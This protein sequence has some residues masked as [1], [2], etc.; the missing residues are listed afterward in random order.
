MR[1]MRVIQ[2]LVLIIALMVFRGMVSINGTVHA[3]GPTSTATGN[4]GNG[5]S[6]LF[7]VD[8]TTLYL[9]DSTTQ[10]KTPY[11]DLLSQTGTELR[12]V[13]IDPAQHFVY[14]VEGPLTQNGLG[15]ETEANQ[16]FQINILTK[17]RKLLFSASDIT[18]LTI[19][20][21]SQLMLT[22]H[23]VSGGRETNTQTLCVLD[24]STGQCTEI[25][26]RIGPGTER[27]IDNQ[28]FVATFQS[29][30]TLHT[31]NA[32]TF[33]QQALPGL[34]S[35]WIYDDVLVPGQ[36]LL[37][38]G[39]H[40][41]T[42]PVTSPAQF[43]TLNLDTSQVTVLAYSAANASY[44]S[45]TDMQLSP[46]G[47]YFLYGDSYNYELVDFHTGTIISE[48][49]K[50]VYVVWT[51]DSQNL[52][53]IQALDDGSYPTI[54]VNAAT[55]QVSQ[56]SASEVGEIIPQQAL[57]TVTP[58]PQPTNTP[59]STPTAT[60]TPSVDDLRTQVNI[61]VTDD[62]LKNSLTV[63]INAGQLSAFINEV[64]AQSGKKIDQ[65]CAK[66]LINLA[67]YLQ[68]NPTPT[69]TKP[70]KTG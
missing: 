34:E 44:V 46:N 51:P 13:K 12:D 67:T 38:I 69:A 19:S 5:S 30:Q 57:M 14:T 65:G 42:A 27:W 3:Q 6:L 41:R 17:D 35:W 64:Q 24:T 21:D 58:T 66:V 70:G 68:K 55:G 16:V 20:P 49:T 4:S 36:R 25:N 54:Q 59:T 26:A 60:S 23:Y 47:N 1:K 63:K 52:I 29:D 22:N 9:W 43:L 39:A 32:K 37:L 8:G 40:S 61:C 33:A 56:L 62:G 53:A 11:L 31:V 50:V 10:N 45:L 28:T 15:T 18:T 7:L 48:L 2:M